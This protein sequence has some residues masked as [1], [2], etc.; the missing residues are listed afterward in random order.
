MNLLV[1]PLLSIIGKKGPRKVSLPQLLA[2]LGRDEVEELPGLQRHQRD[3][4]HVFLCSLAVAVLSRSGDSSPVQTEDYWRQ[5]LRDLA[6]RNDD[7][8]WTLVV[9][10]PDKPA[11]MQPSISEE[12]IKKLKPTEPWP[13]APDALDVLQTAKSLDVKRARIGHP[14]PEDWIYALISLQTMDGYLGSGNFGISRMNSGY[15]SRAIVELV[16]TH[17]PG[18]RWQDAVNRLLRHRQEVLDGPL[19]FDPRGLVLLWTEPWDG[20]VS[21]PLNKLDPNYVEICRRVR[22]SSHEDKIRSATI[23][24]KTRRVDADKLKGMVGDAWLPTDLGSYGSQSARH[25]R[26][27]T[28]SAR[29]L[30]PDLLRRLVFNEGFILSPLQQP[31]NGWQGDM[32]LNI[33]VLVRGQ[34]RTDG[35]HT[36]SVRIPAPVRQHLFAGPAEQNPLADLSRTGIEMAGKMERSVLRTAV[37]S[38]LQGAPENIEFGRDSTQ[39][40]WT[41]FARRYQ[42]LW[43]GDYFPWL[44]SAADL[45]DEQEAQRQWA[46]QL[47]EHARLVLEEA[48]QALPQFGGRQYRSLVRSEGIFWGSLRR[49]F[50]ILKE[51]QNV[52]VKAGSQ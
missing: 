52:E 21:L 45:S 35:F 50:P 12:D 1:D 17:R 8:A 13:T 4:F 26:A 18:G 44:W 51:E 9:T 46:Q 3:A 43:A 36:Q 41:K 49:N 30:T 24:S 2:L 38:F 15:G 7:A 16:R 10:D 48:Q 39:A 31:E 47:K 33:S 37:F 20:Q 42:A 6:G 40:W 19:G 23:G 27:L 25:D 14:A 28:V 11:F 29:G 34:G 32:W 5:G 22:L